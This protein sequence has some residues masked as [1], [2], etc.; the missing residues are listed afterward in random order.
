MFFSEV[1]GDILLDG[2]LLYLTFVVMWIAA[3]FNIKFH[4]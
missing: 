2:I 1:I 4:F 3:Q